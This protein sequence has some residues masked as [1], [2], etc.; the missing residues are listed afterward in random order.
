M[1]CHGS[2]FKRPVLFDEYS[3]LVTA[4]EVI[5]PPPQLKRKRARLLPSPSGRRP[6]HLSRCPRSI[7]S[8][9]SSSSEHW[10]RGL[11]ASRCAGFRRAER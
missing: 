9:M 4:A 10:P 6:A 7:G 8:E 5:I 3:E 1:A 2:F 11:E